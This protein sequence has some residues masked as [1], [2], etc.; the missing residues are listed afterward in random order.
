MD[1]YLRR[2]VEKTVTDDLK[3]KM[4]FVGG[5]RQSGKTTM[6][7]RLCQEAG[8]DTKKRY[9]NWDAPEDRENIITE[10]FPAGPGYLVLDEIH[11][12]SRWRQV[13]KGLYD[14]RGHELQILV[15]GSARLDYYRR[16]GDSL[17]GRYHFYRLFPVSYAELATPSSST[18]TDLLAYG[19]FPEPF[20]RQSERETKRWSREYRSRVVRGEL[21]DLENVQDVGIIEKM[22]LRMPDLVGSPLS[23]NALREDLQVSHQ[24]VARWITMLENL[25]MIFR[26]Y[27]FGAAKIRA[28]KK[29][30]KHY[31]LDWTVVKNTG[32]R[33]ENLVACH[34]LKWCFF[35]EDTQ[36]RDVEL[37]YFRDVDRREVD[38]VVVE[39]GQPIHFV[40]CRKSGKDLSRSL[41]Y[42]KVRFPS[43][44][45]T[46]VLLEKDVDLVTKEG[47]R[48]CS[49][50]LF[51]DQFV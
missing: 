39:D 12:Y 9:L 37:R 38:F 34:L 16:G 24:S 42:L 51:L 11:K 35:V 23:I 41:R 31:H 33:F 48:I 25:Y 40:E 50:H 15:T 46:Q 29:E 28:V 47:I 21:T 43:V 30:A 8:F 32:Y 4:V 7:K 2:Y 44:E 27:P 22:V 49:A 17:R 18:V 26:I 10:R 6:A 45:A 1:A 36:G 3:R 20:M 14:K 5:P 19:G 13:V